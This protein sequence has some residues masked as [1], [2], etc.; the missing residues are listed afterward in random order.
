MIPA[1]ICICFRDSHGQYPAIIQHLPKEESAFASVYEIYEYLKNFRS[2]D[3][4]DLD[5]RNASA[6]IPVR[7]ISINIYRYIREVKRNPIIEDFRPSSI[8]FSVIAVAALALRHGVCVKRLPAIRD[9]SYV[10]RHFPIEC[11]GSNF[12]FA[13]ASRIVLFLKSTLCSFSYSKR[14]CDQLLF[15]YAF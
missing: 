14:D 11:L 7:Y 6:S 8:I 2:R 3:E 13:F 4:R 1:G 12:P 10:I 9:L 5:S 15:Q